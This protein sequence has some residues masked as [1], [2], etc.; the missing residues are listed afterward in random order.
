MK[1]NTPLFSKL[2][3]FLLGEVHESLNFLRGPFEVLDGEYVRTHTA[4]T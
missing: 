3:Q 4:H 1:N 2:E